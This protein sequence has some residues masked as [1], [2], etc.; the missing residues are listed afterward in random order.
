MNPVTQHP[1]LSEEALDDL[2]I[3]LGTAEAEAHL[4]HCAAC[5][6]RVEAFE[7]DLTLF[8]QT[9]LDW[10]RVRAAALPAPEKTGNRPWHLT[11]MGWA[12]AMLFLLAVFLPTQQ[13]R[14]RPQRS[15]P[16]QP[17][18]VQESDSAQQIAQ[19][20]ALMQEVDTAINTDEAS[21]MHAYHLTDQ[22]PMR[23]K[24]RLNDN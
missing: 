24:A 1:H 13:Y 2:L 23:R 18:P 6:A 11:T 5:R 4:A 10:S 21:S 16:V 19:D 20:N 8:R 9:T 3:G 22:S 17:V 7:A 12:V 14:L 15:M